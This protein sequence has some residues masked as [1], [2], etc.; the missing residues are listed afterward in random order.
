MAEKSGGIEHRWNG[1][2]RYKWILIFVLIRVI[3]GRKLL[4]TDSTD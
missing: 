2:N 1:Y 3:R 4:T